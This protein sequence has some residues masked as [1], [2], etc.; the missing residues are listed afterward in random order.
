M[1][2]LKWIFKFIVYGWKLDYHLNKQNKFNKVDHPHILNYHYEMSKY[3][4]KKL[5]NKEP[6]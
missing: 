2:E 4:Y 3:Y 6:K 1:K 5:Y